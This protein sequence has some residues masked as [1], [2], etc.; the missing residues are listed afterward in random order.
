MVP[1]LATRLS[2][3]L[4]GSC[5][6]GV[7]SRGST[8]LERRNLAPWPSRHCKRNWRWWREARLC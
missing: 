7:G 5:R 1:G 2:E 6:E 4:E 3:A 8:A